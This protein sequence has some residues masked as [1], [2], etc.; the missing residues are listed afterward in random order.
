M[1]LIKG[2]RS[3]LDALCVSN[4]STN[5]GANEEKTKTGH[6]KKKHGGKGTLLVLL[7]T[8]G[9]EFR[10]IFKTVTVLWMQYLQVLLL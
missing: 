10:R 5:C 6:I 3:C 7:F 4:I 1:Q 2:T 8:P 9:L